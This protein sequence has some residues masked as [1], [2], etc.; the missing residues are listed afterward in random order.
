LHAWRLRFL[1]PRTMEEM[2]VTAPLPKDMNR[3]ARKIMVNHPYVGDFLEEEEEA[4]GEEVAEVVEEV[5]EVG[6]VGVEEEQQEETEKQDLQKQME[7]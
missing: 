4:V 2:E 6:V 7:V 1:H 3:A 5:E